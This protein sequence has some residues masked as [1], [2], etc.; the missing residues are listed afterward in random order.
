MM[1]HRKLDGR[2]KRALDTAIAKRQVSQE[3]YRAVLA[4]EITLQEAKAIGRD[5][6][7]PADTARGSSGPETD[8]GISGGASAMGGR[9]GTDT[10]PQ[11][12]SRISKNDKTRLCMCGCG[13]A[14]S[15]RFAVGHDQR[16]LKFA[17]EHLKGERELTGEQLAYVRDE[18]NKLERAKARV[19]R[20]DQRKRQK[21]DSQ[22]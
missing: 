21:A 16:L 7:P 19:E 13:R 17:Y 2:T 9:D 4:G 22:P 14:T 3:S 5:G 11:P 15:G 20:G 8:T 18:T 1:Q 10:P 12:V 6:A